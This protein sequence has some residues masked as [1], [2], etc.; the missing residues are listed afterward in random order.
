[1]FHSELKTLG[2]DLD[3]TFAWMANGFTVD[4]CNPNGIKDLT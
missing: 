4:V 1:M 3:L 2:D